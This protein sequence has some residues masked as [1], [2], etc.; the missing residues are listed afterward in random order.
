MEISDLDT[1]PLRQVHAWVEAAR[2]AGAP[3][4]GA[5]TLATITTEGRPAARMVLLRAVDQGV[6]FCTDATSDKAA[7]LAA[8]GQAAAVL[9]WREPVP[10]QVR[11]AGMTE[12]ISDE[13]SDRYWS[14]RTRAVKLG[15]LASSQSRVLASREKLEEDVRLLDQQF[16]GG[17][18]LPRP[19]RWRGLRIV[20]ETIEFWQEAPDA[21]H[22][23]I[24]FLRS[25]RGGRWTSER[26]YP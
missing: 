16:P 14:D 15:A 25:G 17:T 1:D 8:S 12:A 23:R 24:R 4:P 13:D 26:L 6:V 3:V 2:A 20:P 11:L 18:D 22:D 9:Y 5:M 7:E 10:R 21:L 19:E